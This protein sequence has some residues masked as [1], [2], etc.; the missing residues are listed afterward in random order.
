VLRFLSQEPCCQWRP[1][2]GR[3]AA[4]RPRTGQYVRGEIC[5]PTNSTCKYSICAEVHDDWSCNLITF[6]NGQVLASMTTDCGTLRTSL[7]Q[8]MRRRR[9]SQP[10]AP[11]SQPWLWKPPGLPAA[12]P[13]QR[14]PLAILARRLDPRQAGQGF[15]D[16]AQGHRETAVHQGTATGH[17]HAL[18]HPVAGPGWRLLPEARLPAFRSVIS[19]TRMQFTDHL[20]Q[21]TVAFAR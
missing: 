4:R 8:K 3:P 12:R 10:A 18:R 19:G 16:K 20:G 5:R 11:G 1:L 14:D 15:R 7:S 2:R 17:S 21:A 13:A 6:R 9:R